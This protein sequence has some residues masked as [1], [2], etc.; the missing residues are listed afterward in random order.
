MRYAYLLAILLFA[1]QSTQQKVA[2][3][4]QPNIILI[5]TDDLGYGDLS[6]YGHPTIHTPRLDQMAQEGIRLTSFYTAAPVCT[7]SRA[8]LLT[9]RYP[10]RFGMPG[11]LGP[12]SPGGFPA[13]EQSLAEALKDKG[14]HTAAIGKWHLGAVAGHFPTDHGFDE[15]FGILYSNDMEPPW[16]ETDRE[17]RLYRNDQPTDEYPVDQRTLTERYTQEAID[18]INAH[19]DEPFFIYLPHAMPHLPI[20]ASTQ[21]QGTSAGGRIGDV[22]E[23][24]DWSTGQ[25]LD[26][27][28]AAGLDEHTMVIFTS[29]NGPWSNMPPRMYDT[30]PVERWDA[31]VAGALNGTKA[32]T[33]EG[34]PR[35]PCIIRWPGRIPTKQVSAQQATTMD[36]HAS[37]LGLVGA[38]A[39][40]DRPLDGDDMMPFLQGKAA[41][42]ARTYFYYWLD[43]LQAVRNG[44]WKYR[45]AQMDGELKEELFNLKEDPAERYNVIEAY[46]ER[47]TTLKKQLIAFARETKARLDF[48]TD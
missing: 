6:C 26:A 22:V 48:E 35:V 28:K 24:L 4:R 19:Q 15:Y 47:A 27:V 8:G 32:T 1:C 13:E 14:Y 11:N 25:I 44:D 31:G 21:F 29:D 17:L 46:P 43:R 45:H 18:V 30:E 37:I 40:P 7:P 42:P 10:I 39:L 2:K 20:S 33:Y 41:A 9:G 12:D 38:E 23:S 3:E 34:G 5:Y 36:L 16:V